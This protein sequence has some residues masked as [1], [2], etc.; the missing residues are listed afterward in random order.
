[1]VPSL[2]ALKKQALDV[3]RLVDLMGGVMEPVLSQQG[4]GSTFSFRLPLHVSVLHRGPVFS[5][6]EA[7]ALRGIRIL[8][9][10]QNEFERKTLETMLDAWKIQQEA[11]ASLEDL[12]NH[13]SYINQF[14]LLLLSEPIC[15]L[16]DQKELKTPF[17]YLSPLESMECQEQA[18]V[19]S[20]L[21][22]KP[23]TEV[24][25]WQAI[26]QVII[27]EEKELEVVPVP[28]AT[29]AIDT[30]FAQAFP[31]R[32]LVAEDNKVN[33]QVMWSLLNRLGYRATLVD[34]GERVLERLSEEQFDLIFMD[35][36]MPKMDGVAATKVIR[37]QHRDPRYPVIVAL[38]ANAVREDLEGYL[39]DG[40]NDLL[41]KPYLIEDMQGLLAKY[42]REVG[43]MSPH[44]EKTGPGD[45]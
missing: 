22:R 40:M 8:I 3:K 32:I 20:M 26:T 38:T 45:S 18:H 33:Q 10:E 23:I 7:K 31:L 14:D 37:T 17:I 29:W 36:Q 39:K 13:Y 2:Q 9:L 44:S 34:N 12:S 5:A 35:I 1:G 27:G 19:T 16:L 28:P 4:T 42:A 15:Q 6:L 30:S 41:V 25:L 11:L 24:G 21:L 43:S